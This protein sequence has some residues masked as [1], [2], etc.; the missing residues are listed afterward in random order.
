MLRYADMEEQVD[1]GFTRARHTALVH[2]LKDRVLSDPS[3]RYLVERDEVRKTGGA[4]SNR[5][6]GRRVV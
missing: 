2:R 4:D 5:F 6:P 1:E 3:P